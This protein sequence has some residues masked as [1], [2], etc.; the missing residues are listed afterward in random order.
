MDDGDTIAAV[1]TPSGEGGI[2]VIRV[3]GPS[4]L[5]AVSRL[6]SPVDN[7]E[8][9]KA[10][11]R[12]LSLPGEDEVIEQALLTYF[13]APNS[14]TGEDVV[15]ISCHGSPVLLRTLLDSLVRGDS[16]RMAEPGEFTRRAFE[17]DKLDLAQADAVASMIS[18]RS[19]AALRASA[20]QLK[21]EL[22]EAVTELRETLVYCQSRVEAGLDFGDEDSVGDIP[23]DE[24]KDRL[25][26]VDSRLSDLI[27]EG[28]R[29]T[30]MEEGCRVVIAG[31]P[32]VGKS[33]LLNKLLREDRAIVTE[34]PGTTR[35]VISDQIVIDGI[36]FELRD[37][38]GIRPDPETIEAEG[39]RR[40]KEAVA[41]ADLVVFMV[42]GIEPLNKA[43]RRIHEL[44]EGETS[45]LVL[46][47]IDRPA[48]IDE[49]TIEAEFGRG[50]DLSISAKT[51]EG[52]D[53]LRRAMTDAVLE[54]DVNVENPLVTRTRHLDVLRRT[55][56][57][58]ERAMN[59]IERRMDPPLIAED[60]RE[61]A[62][63]AGE[64][65]GTITTDDL[66]DEIFSSFCIG[67]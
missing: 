51:G 59:G 65:T 22:S 18:A 29:G 17:N 31:R 12:E 1:A 66:L 5:E 8:P 15:E 23:Y 42:D 21:G 41:E 26:Q 60:L 45:L 3:S 7:L 36:P 13:P 10:S 48:A 50:V 20:R 27:E 43:D 25:N 67:K 64:I 2:G 62:D 33:S 19:E 49:E 58:L 63:H 47:K 55:R 14:Y 9:R 28:E 61:A 34:Q 46:N 11:L 38:A 35:D 37:T 4:S 40:S 32:N 56:E 54:G 30:L 53:T 16:A 24:I 52:L 39:I 6:S 57:S 44:V